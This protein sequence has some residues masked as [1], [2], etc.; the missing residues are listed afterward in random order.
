M[1]KTLEKLGSNFYFIPSSIHE[2]LLFPMTDITSVE[3]IENI[4]GEVNST[5]VQD[6]E[7]L[8]DHVYTYSLE[9]GLQSVACMNS[10]IQDCFTEYTM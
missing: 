5:L 7:L 1:K 2:L 10:A 4:I 9:H 8:S 6:D 3:E